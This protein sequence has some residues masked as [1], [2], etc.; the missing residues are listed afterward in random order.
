MRARGMLA[1]VALAA[2]PAMADTTAPKV[3]LFG[4]YS[5]TKNG[6]QSLNGGEGTLA[7]SLNPWFGAEADLSLHYG[8]ALGTHTSRLFFMAGPRLAHRGGNINVFTHALAGGVRSGSG[9]TVVSVNITQTR[10]DLALAFGGGVD[11]RLSDRW[12]VRA[13]AD[14]VLIRADGAT[15]KEPRFSAGFLY[16]VR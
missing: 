5:Y 9:L 1:L 8:S 6:G 10:T 16:R 13:Q 3:E 12:A 11:A 4:G 7:I 15:E 14:Y 2:A